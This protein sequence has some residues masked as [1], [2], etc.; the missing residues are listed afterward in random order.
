[1]ESIQKLLEKVRK[2]ET[3]FK[4]AEGKKQIVW[5]EVYIPDVPDAHG[6]YMTAEDIEEMAYEFMKRGLLKSLDVQHDNQ[7][8]GCMVVESFI[9]REGD[10]VFVPGAW[11]LGVWCPEPIWKLVEKG[12]LN[13]FSLQGMSECIDD[14]LVINVPDTIWGETLPDPVDGHVHKFQVKFDSEGNFLGGLCE[15]NCN[16]S[17]VIV[18][19]TVTEESRGHSHRFSF[20]EG[21]GDVSGEHGGSPAN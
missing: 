8:Y 3:V 12:E 6:D 19:G 7:I 13:G 1:M 21:L 11:V 2:R 10:P 20:V 17:H 4:A 18:K 16:H 5:G 15:V 14:P 9:A